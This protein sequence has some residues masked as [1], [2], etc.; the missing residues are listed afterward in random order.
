MALRMPPAFC[1]AGDGRQ[2][3]PGPAPQR[4]RL[5]LAGKSHVAVVRE[6]ERLLLVN[7]PPGMSFHADQADELGLVE[8]RSLRSFVLSVLNYYPVLASGV[9]S[10]GTIRCPILIY[11]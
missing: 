8:V 6:T 3:T 9:L 11:V 10:S 2:S 1:V 5:A 7:K 4:Q